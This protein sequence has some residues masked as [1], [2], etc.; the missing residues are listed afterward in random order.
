MDKKNKCTICG[1]EGMRTQLHHIIP[2]KDGG[3]DIDKNL[4]EV[5]PNCHAEAT[6]DEAA[7][8]IK[9]GLEGVR[10]NKEKINAMDESGLIWS[11]LLKNN[12]FNDLKLFNRLIK[13][14]KEYDLKRFYKK[15]NQ[16]EKRVG[17]TKLEFDNIISNTKKIPF[18]I[19]FLLAYGSGLRL[20]EIVG[21]DRNIKPISKEDIDIENKT[22]I[23]NNNGSSRLVPI[24]PKLKNYMLEFLPLTKSFLNVSSARRSLQ[25]GFKVAAKKSGILNKKP[26]ACFGSLRVGF[27]YVLAKKGIPLDIFRKMMGASSAN[28]I[29]YL[30][31]EDVGNIRKEIID[32][33]KL[34]INNG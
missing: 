11:H 15:D 21:D 22:I 10:M 33:Y 34:L 6:T 31:C 28:F 16:I 7:F 24:S 8:R 23:I 17:L 9:Y 4:I 32:H 29:D 14:E 20:G 25:R 5:C 3:E 27:G 13:L 2:M 12:F 19:A 30:T 1:W 18:K 26:Q